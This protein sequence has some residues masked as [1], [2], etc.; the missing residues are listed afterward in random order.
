MDYILYED[1]KTFC[2]DRIKGITGVL[3]IAGQK[4]RGGR[5]F[6]KFLKGPGLT[7]HLYFTAKA[8]KTA[9]IFNNLAVW[10]VK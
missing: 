9:M 2:N 4:G 3:Q 1:G 8:V 10:T 6:L 5:I 7:I